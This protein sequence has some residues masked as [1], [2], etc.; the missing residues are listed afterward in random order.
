MK[1]AILQGF[2][3]AV[4]AIACTIMVL[5]LQLPENGELA[6][7]LKEWPVF[8]SHFNSFIIIYI[9]WVNH[10]KVLDKVDNVGIDVILLNGF[11]LV[12]L[13]LFPFATNY[14]ENFYQDVT[15]EALFLILT[16]ILLFLNNRII[17]RVIRE[18]PNTKFPERIPLLQRMPMYI[19]LGLC[20]INL[21]FIPDLNLFLLLL[22][23]IYMVI[24]MLKYMHKEIRIN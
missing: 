1:S 4:V 18:N 10:A 19:L 5:E 23:N 6:S 11:W 24:L 22:V 13:A 20:L 9:L 21:F 7:L 17:N 16:I 3:A 14:V 12:F 2:T 15:P 8:L